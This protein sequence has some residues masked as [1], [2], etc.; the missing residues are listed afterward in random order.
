ME[1]KI[2]YKK[3]D[4]TKVVQIKKLFCF[5]KNNY[6]SIDILINCAGIQHVSSVENYSEDFQSLHGI[7]ISSDG[8]TLFVSGMR[9]GHLHLFNAPDLQLIKSIPLG[10]NYSFAS[11]GGVKVK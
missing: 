1:R 11:P 8:K 5:I 9:D 3:I 2:F 4:L 6:S 7:D 10:E